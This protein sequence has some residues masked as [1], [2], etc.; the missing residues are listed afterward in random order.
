[1]TLCNTDMFNKQAVWIQ[2]ALTGHLTFV[3]SCILSIQGMSLKQD[4][5]WS[6]IFTVTSI[7]PCI[8][9]EHGFYNINIDTMV[10]ISHYIDSTTDILVVI[11]SQ[12]TINWF[13][14]CLITIVGISKQKLPVKYTRW[15]LLVGLIHGYSFLSV[16]ILC[17]L[18]L[19]Y[20]Q[21]TFLNQCITNTHA[22]IF[23]KKSVGCKTLNILVEGYILWQ[24]RCLHRFPHR[25]RYTPLCFA[26]IS[27]CSA[28]VYCYYYIADTKTS[29]KSVI[30]EITD[31][32]IHPSYNAILQCESCKKCLTNIDVEEPI[33]A[34]VYS[35][36]YI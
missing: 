13:N 11:G 16:L 31:H 27:I 14:I 4:L 23:L 24:M 29:Q 18:L 25:L 3:L 7:I 17:R 15:F 34:N 21:L 19:Q 2:I 33:R 1:M 8:V 32:G 12:I 9:A 28:I 36:D 6:L 10:T 5:I 35:D 22:T 30:Q 20:K 26:F